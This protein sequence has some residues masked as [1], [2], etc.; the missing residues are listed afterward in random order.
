VTMLPSHAS[1]GTARA[2]WSRCDV[3]VRVTL[4]TMLPSHAGDGTVGVTWPQR[5]VYVKS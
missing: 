5:D 4:V 1:D 3:D 2:T